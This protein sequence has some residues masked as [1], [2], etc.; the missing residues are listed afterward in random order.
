M[1]KAFEHQPTSQHTPHSTS[2]ADDCKPQ[3][4]RQTLTSEF[5]SSTRTVMRASNARLAACACNT[6]NTMATSSTDKLQGVKVTPRYRQSLP[7][8]A[9]PA[10]A[11]GQNAPDPL[12]ASQWECR[13]RQQ[14]SYICMH[15]ASHVV[16]GPDHK[17]TAQRPTVWCRP[18]QTLPRAP[19]C[20]GNHLHIV[21]SIVGGVVVSQ[22]PVVPGLT[23]TVTD[24]V[25]DAPLASVAVNLT[26]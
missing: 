9:C 14:L 4:R 16:S 3:T 1:G 7:A 24:P 11:H 19:A 23:Q 12:R 21:A 2:Q 13:H 17:Q 10:A 18:T 6:S 26:R 22:L 8:H 5:R 20:G 25:Q 15:E